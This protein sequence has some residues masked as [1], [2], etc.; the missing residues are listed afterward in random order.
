MTSTT[1]HRRALATLAAAALATGAGAPVA[2]AQPIDDVPPPPSRIAVSAADEYQDL[3]MPDTRD[4]AND[5]H[6]TLHA[7]TSTAAG[8][9][10]FDV[11]SAAI[12]A[13]AGAGLGLVAL[14][15]GGV[16]RRHPPGG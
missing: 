4:A 6:P 11:A 1:K 12:G 15:L 10:G 13:A 9:G 7:S 2:L 3:R 16:A 8:S 5:Y 14:G